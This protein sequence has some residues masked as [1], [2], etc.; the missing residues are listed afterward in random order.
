MSNAL[1]Y[2]NE[3]ELEL[4]L[5]NE[6]TDFDNFYKHELVEML[7]IARNILNQ[8][9]KLNASNLSWLVGKYINNQ[10]V[11]KI[12]YEPYKDEIE[13]VLENYDR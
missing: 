3:Y 5:K 2:F 6:N 4:I 9:V 11:L 13:I 12:D 8:G 7:K 10:K 1:K